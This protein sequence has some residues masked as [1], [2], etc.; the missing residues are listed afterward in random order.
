MA[1]MMTLGVFEPEPLPDIPRGIRVSYQTAS[2]DGDMPERRETGGTMTEPIRAQD[3][4]VYVGV[5]VYGRGVVMLPVNSL[6]I[7][8]LCPTRGCTAWLERLRAVRRRHHDDH[9]DG[10][11]PPACSLPRQVRYPPPAFPVRGET[12]WTRVR[13]H[14]RIAISL[15]GEQKAGFR[16]GPGLSLC[17]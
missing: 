9:R 16:M 17:W 13:R 6:P 7:T 15:L 8:R 3:G 2:A 12:V 10:A 14:V 1:V 4:L 11:V 5:S